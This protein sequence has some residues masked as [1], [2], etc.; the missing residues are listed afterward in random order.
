MRSTLLA[1]GWNEAMSST[2]VSVDRCSYVCAATRDRRA[3][4]Q[5][6]ERRGR[7]AS[8]V[9]DPGHAGDD[10]GQPEPQRGRCT[11]LRNGHGVQRNDAREWRN[12]PRLSIGATGLSSVEGPHAP[13][14]PLDFFDVKGS[15]EEL[16]SRFASR[17]LYFDNFAADA[18]DTRVASSGTLGSYRGGWID[19]RLLRTVAS[20]GGAAAQ[21]Q[22]NRIRG[23]NLPR[24][25]SIDRHC[26]SRR[27][28]NYPASSRYVAI[29]R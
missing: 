24:T 22:A 8:A 27:F 7:H 25:G 1:L 28:A 18:P 11:P 4:G 20:R 14:R 26:D 10:C 21:N 3:D 6:V 15:V 5:S 16:L 12:G 29:F 19:D 2:F 23:R 13:P 9:A 17:S